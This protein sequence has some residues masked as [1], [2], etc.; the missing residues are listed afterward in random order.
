MLLMTGDQIYADDV[1]MPLL[2]ILSGIGQELLGPVKEKITSD[3]GSFE[4]NQENFPA[5]FRG[6][7]LQTKAGFT[8]ASTSHLTSFGEYAAMYLAVWNN[9]FWPLPEQDG[10]FPEF[11]FTLFEDLLA[12]INP[13]TDELI[14]TWKELF[15]SPKKIELEAGELETFLFHF[16]VTL[17]RDTLLKF[18]DKDAEVKFDPRTLEKTLLPNVSGEVRKTY[19]LTYN[20]ATA[21]SDEKLL[22]FKEFVKSLQK[23]FIGKQRASTEQLSHIKLLYTTLPQVRR[24]MANVP[25]YMM[26]DDHDVTDD[27][28][29][30]GAWRDQVLT[31]DAGATVLRNGMVA[32]VMFQLWER[33]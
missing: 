11:K 1:A 22:K 10:S 28:Y 32:G 8:T 23:R 31:K 26:W 21:L 18:F 7:F 20:F 17:P 16:F 5:G 25:C 3:A 29:I 15:R 30:T 9:L 6:K 2:P 33:P 4:I 13:K 24:A 14:P 19:E 12:R 27:W